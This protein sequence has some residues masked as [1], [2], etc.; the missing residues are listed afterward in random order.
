[1]TRRWGR[2]HDE[3]PVATTPKP[4]DVRMTAWVHG[5]V[6][7]VGFRWWTRSR[8][9]ELGLV[10]SASNLADGRVEV[11]V[12]GSREACDA[13]LAQLRG[14]KTPGGVDQVVAQFADARG[15]FR[16]FTER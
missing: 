6:Q 4:G 8:A 2:A 12:E 11:V 16:G 5:F 14:A 3:Q 13:L 1:M 9:L 7:G 15:G 10:G